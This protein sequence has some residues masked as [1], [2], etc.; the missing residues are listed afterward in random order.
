[1]ESRDQE[2]SFLRRI[3]VG[4]IGNVMEWYDFAVYGYFAGTIGQLFFPSNNPVVSLIASFGAFAAGFLV[5]PLGGLVFGRIGD[6]VGRQRA[7]LLSVMAMAIPTVVMGLLPTYGMIGVAA[8]VLLVMLRLIQGLSVGGE[9]TSSLVFLVEHAPPGRRAF[10]AV[11]GAWGASAG[12]LLG[13]GVGFF[14]AMLLT[15]EQ[16]QSWGWRVPFLL[17]GCVA[18][19]GLWLRQG[20][21]VEA[22]PAH[23]KAPTREVFT[24]YLR[25]VLRVALLNLGFG[26]GFYTVFVYA[27]SYME[28]V[29]KLSD[30]ISL[31]NNS[32]AMLL[33][34]VI[35]PFAAK[36]ADRHGRKVVL[37]VGFS[38]LTL[39]PIPLFHL[40]GLGIPWLIIVC[41]L[42]LAL[43][44]GI[45][46]GAIAACNV[47][48]MPRAV[49]CTGLAFAYNLAVGG[50]GGITPLAVTWLTVYLHS[51]TAPGYWV[52]GAAMISAFTLWFLVAETRHRS[53]DH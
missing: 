53:L 5:R 17:G 42:A 15:P 27:V 32:M 23:S 9:Y 33:L 1:M 47:E 35:M 43:P 2:P 11:W 7:M 21:Q 26:A 4:L 25:P 24:T 41:D 16:L 28:R 50:F 29:G 10:S 6:L 40:M 14:T 12:T 37:G 20:M 44:L 36:Y 51:P 19:V 52:A 22:P 38:L 39:L 8:P 13:S 46:G 30:Q 34:L 49:R 31:R 45:V 18:A 3:L 48:L